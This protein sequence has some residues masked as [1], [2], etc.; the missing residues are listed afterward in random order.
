M[1]VHTRSVGGSLTEYHGVAGT[2]SLCY[3]LRHGCVGHGCVCRK[4]PMKFFDR[5][6]EI[7]R[8]REIRERASTTSQFTVITGRR[9][10]GKTEL[11]AYN[12]TRKFKKAE[13]F[14]A[15]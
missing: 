11:L 3:T 5:T 10:V 9:R 14:C 8:L 2:I 4:V 1:N 7:A 6:D 15:Y 12:L 13:F